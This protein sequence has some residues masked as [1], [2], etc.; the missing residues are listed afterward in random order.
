MLAL[1]FVHPLR[2]TS[3]NRWVRVYARRFY[4]SLF[5]LVGLL[6]LGTWRRVSEYG[7][8]EKRYLLIALGL[9]IA[10]VAL[11]FVTS[12]RRDIRVIPVSLCAVALLASFGPWSASNVSRADQIARLRDILVPHGLLAGGKVRPARAEVDFATR[13]AI[14]AGLDYLNRVHHGAGVKSWFDAEALRPQSGAESPTALSTPRMMNAM[15]LA[16]VGRWQTQ[17]NEGFSLSAHRDP[18]DDS[19]VAIPLDGYPGMVMISL[20][21]YTGKE[22]PR[23]LWLSDRRFSLEL[24]DSGDLRVWDDS[25]SVSIPLAR[26]ASRLRM[27]YP[28]PMH[29]PS[30]AEMTTEAL[31]LGLDAKL[32]LTGMIGR[33]RS[34]G[35][36][37]SDPAELQVQQVDGTLFLR[38]R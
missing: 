13:Q 25:A 8:T 29:G 9:W 16:Y 27:D 23:T 10:G 26:L 7:I 12:R 17:G 5:P 11:A 21:R 1:L 32:V 20:Y 14:S 19:L 37:T 22:P 4:F 2:E 35:A 30:S 15:G 38:P 34:P 28:T 3:E 6:M 36:A 18:H 31:G 24:E 33:V